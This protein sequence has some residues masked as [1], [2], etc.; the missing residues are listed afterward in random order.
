M[1]VVYVIGLPGSG[2]TTMADGAVDHLG[3]TGIEVIGGVPFTDYGWLWHLG[4]RR[5]DFGGTDAMSMSINPRA[6]EMV[7]TATYDVILG[8]GDRLANAKFLAACPDLT[9][10]YLDTPF[11]VARERMV[12]RAERMGSEPQSWSW[13]KG[14][15]TKVDNLIARHAHLRYDGTLAPEELSAQLAAA[16]ISRRSP[17]A[18][19]SPAPGQR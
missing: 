1:A 6:V 9:L 2:K 8:E 11:T 10:I 14:R 18:L 15:L 17:A 3:L 19:P 16:L 12:A 4:R 7:T 13:W 5:R